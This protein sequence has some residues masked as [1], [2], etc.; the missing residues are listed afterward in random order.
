ML[1][2]AAISR[3]CLRIFALY[4]SLVGVGYLGVVSASGGGECVSLVVDVVGVEV[5]VGVGIF[6]GVAVLEVVSGWGCS[7]LGAF[8]L[9]RPLRCSLSCCTSVPSI[10]YCINI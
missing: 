4:I 9:K 2:V 3:L 7:W 8:L 1:L 6:S 10:I 5:V